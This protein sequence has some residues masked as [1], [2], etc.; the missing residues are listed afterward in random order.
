MN[1]PCP[2]GAEREGMPWPMGYWVQC[3]KHGVDH[4]EYIAWA[5][6]GTIRRRGYY[7]DGKRHGQ[8]MSQYDGRLW[9]EYYD[10]GFRAG[11]WSEYRPDGGLASLQHWARDRRTGVQRQWNEDGVLVGEQIYDDGV[12]VG[13]WR[14]WNEDGELVENTD[15]DHPSGETGQTIR[16]TY[17]HRPYQVITRR[18]GLLDGPSFR[19]HPRSGQVSSIIYYDR[20]R[21]EWSFYV[22]Q[23][24]TK[25]P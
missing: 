3:R 15:W 16:R 25:T 14:R 13:H 20:G 21:Y 24:R 8:W 12:P 4:G 11:T 19:L 22:G 2:D 9:V 7:V 5:D 23:A 1:T 18:N 6:D 10:R 17:N